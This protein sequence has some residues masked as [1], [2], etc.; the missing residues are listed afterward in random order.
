MKD[1]ASQEKSN[2]PQK[3]ASN[4]EFELHIQVKNT[5]EATARE[6]L[7][8]IQGLVNDVGILGCLDVINNIK[9]YPVEFRK[10]LSLMGNPMVM[11]MLRNF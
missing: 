7:V 11:A 6:L 4:G 5:D 3:P 10:A 1:D 9:Q 8:G 2:K